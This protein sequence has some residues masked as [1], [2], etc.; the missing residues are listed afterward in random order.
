MA[1]SSADEKLLEAKAD[2]LAWTLTDALGYFADN[3]FVLE[4]VIAQSARGNS[5]VIQFAQ[6]EDLPKVVKLK[7]RGWP[8]LG[9]GMKI[10][11]T[12]DSQG[13][14]LAVEKSSI[15]V[16]PY[17]SDTE[18]P[19]FRVEYVKDQDSHRPSSHIHV[20]AHRDEFTHLM[21]FA[22]KFDVERT[23]KVRNYFRRGTRL[24][25]LH[26]PTGGHRFRPCLED[27]LEMLRVE[28]KLD[29]DNGKWQQ[30]LRTAR[31]NWRRTQ[32]AAAVRDCPD[33]ALRVLVDE[34]GMPEP[35]GW[36]LPEFDTAWQKKFA[37]S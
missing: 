30:H 8:V 32:L 21:G 34:Y 4:T 24:S 16:M 26:F 28:F 20:H 11:C 22:S 27:V 15:R 6:K 29:V 10:N 23:K 7:S 3:D 13:K 1:L 36:T 33:E 35:I 2:E 14:H 9:L 19:L 37:R 25:E 17:G 5:I 12:W 18:A 31:E